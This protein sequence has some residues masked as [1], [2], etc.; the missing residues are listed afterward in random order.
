MKNKF[1]FA[2]IIT[3]EKGQMGQIKK[4]YK[5]LDLPYNASLEEVKLRQ[6]V[7]IKLI[8]AKGLKSGKLNEKKIK[9]INIAANKI[10]FYINKN[11]PAK[12]SGTRFETSFDDVVNLIFAFLFS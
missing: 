12:T 11:G 2:I 10:E 3:I 8:R 4:C 5:I 1:E 9:E 6:K 7:L